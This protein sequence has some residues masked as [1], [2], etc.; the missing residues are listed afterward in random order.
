MHLH[1]C[2]FKPLHNKTCLVRGLP[3]RGYHSHPRPLLQFRAWLWAR[4][5]GH[6]HDPWLQLQLWERD[7]QPPCR[8]LN[9]SWGC[10]SPDPGSGVRRVPLAEVWTWRD[11]RWVL[12]RRL[13]P[14]AVWQSCWEESS[15]WCRDADRKLEIEGKILLGSRCY[16]L[17]NGTLC[18]TITIIP[19]FM[20]QSM[21]RK[22][23]KETLIPTQKV[24]CNI[25]NIG[26][27]DYG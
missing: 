20:F 6:L 3:V 5:L 22:K 21:S 2:V 12:S 4:S 15:P 9:W 17:M 13:Q 25:V 7:P 16:C 27:C 18:F 1:A 10:Q 14:Q 26:F 24:H 23:I 19:T 8:W 11:R